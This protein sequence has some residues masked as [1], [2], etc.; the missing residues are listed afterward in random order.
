MMGRHGKGL[1]KL[2]QNGK[3]LFIILFG[4]NEANIADTPLSHQEEIKPLVTDSAPASEELEQKLKQDQDKT[5]TSDFRPFKCSYCKVSFKRIDHKRRHEKNKHSEAHQQAVK[6]ENILDQS[7]G[8]EDEIANAIRPY[9]CSYC[10]K[11]FKRLDHK[12]RHEDT[13]VK[14]SNNRKMAKRSAEKGDMQMHYLRK[15]S[16]CYRGFKK[17]FHVKRHEEICSTLSPRVIVQQNLVLEGREDML[18]EK[19]HVFPCS[20]CSKSFGKQSHA[21]RHQQTHFPP[22][23]TRYACKKC[24][25]SYSRK[26][27]LKRHMD[28][29]HIKKLV[30][31]CKYCSQ[32]FAVQQD[33]RKHERSHE[34][35]RKRRS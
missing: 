8:A 5:L 31:A 12:W 23:D 34:I 25:C 15:C 4:D 26:H 9:K 30:F 19:K 6:K 29:A 16:Y 17:F 11:G 27:D 21:L 22:D 13:H 10:M 7:V 14:N 24:T 28:R 2:D 18:T 20:Y 32:M 3:Y 33:M 35:R 1:K